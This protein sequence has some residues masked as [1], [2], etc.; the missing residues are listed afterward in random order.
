MAEQT[1]P[2]PTK[3][4]TRKVAAAGLGGTVTSLLVALLAGGFGEEAL[5]MAPEWVHMLIAGLVASAG[6]FGAGY[7]RKSAHAAPPRRLD[8]HEPPASPPRPL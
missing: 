3:A 4:P 6:G 1:Y 5:A 7:A 8:Q 2:Q